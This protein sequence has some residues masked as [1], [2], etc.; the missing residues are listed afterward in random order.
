MIAKRKGKNFKNNKLLS[1]KNKKN[2]ALGKTPGFKC[3]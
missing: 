2:A 3:F 1:K